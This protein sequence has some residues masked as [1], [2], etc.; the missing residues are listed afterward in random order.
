MRRRTFLLAA[1]LLAYFIG[2]SVNAYLRCGPNQLCGDCG[3][4]GYRIVGI[5]QHPRA[6]FNHPLLAVEYLVAPVCND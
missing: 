5:V 6:V 1:G 2:A 3:D 4:V